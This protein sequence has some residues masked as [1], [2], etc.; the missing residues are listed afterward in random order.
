MKALEELFVEKSLELLSSL[1]I[2]SAKTQLTYWTSTSRKPSEVKPYHGGTPSACTED[3]HC[4]PSQATSSAGHQLPETPGHGCASCTDVDFGKP[5]A[6][7]STKSTSQR[8]AHGPSPDLRSRTSSLMPHLLLYLY[9][10][11]QR[12]FLKATTYPKEITNFPVGYTPWDSGKFYKSI[13][14]LRTCRYI[15]S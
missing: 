9:F 6:D 1:P 14:H 5:F 11:Y 13:T 4:P 8:E 7:R 2:Q 12:A 3:H 15:A 10:C